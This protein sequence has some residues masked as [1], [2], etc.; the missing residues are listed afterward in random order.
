MLNRPLAR[1]ARRF[2][3]RAFATTSTRLSKGTPP[4]PLPGVATALAYASRAHAKSAPPHGVSSPPRPTLAESFS[5]QGR[6]ALVS[7]ANRGLGLEMG[8]A[9]AEAGAKVYC[10]DLAPSP[11]AEFK[12]VESYLDSIRESKDADAEAL[13]GGPVG[14]VVYRKANVVDQQE[15]WKLGEAIGNE[16]GRMDVCVAAA[17]ILRPEKDVL[18]YDTEEM[19]EVFDVN[20]HGV[21]HTAQA[22]GRQ[23]ARFGNGGSIILIASMS[24]S[25]TNRD[26]NWVSYNS[27]K[28]AVLQMGRSMA[29]ELGPR[30]IRVNTLS[31]G[32]I[33]TSMT[34]AFLDKQPALQGRW[35]SANPLG[36]LG[37]PDELRGVTAWLAS[38]ASTFCTGSDILVSGGHHAW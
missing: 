35:E 22:A 11:G 13:G 33:Y 34:A 12:A 6:V 28:S 10:V 23:M 3:A 19:H 37:R 14:S 15:M 1:P 7:G 8:L 31:P 17:G 36:R 2:T 27:S 30:R 20:V 18:G 29:C 16:E 24:G 9:L 4:S 38:D 21:L 5:L 25:L 32:H 26:M